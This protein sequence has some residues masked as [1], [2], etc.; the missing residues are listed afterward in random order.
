MPAGPWTDIRCNWITGLLE[1][2][3]VDSILAVIDHLTKMAHFIPCREKMTAKQLA[4]L[5]LRHVQ[6]LH[7]TPETMVPDW[8][9]I[10]ISQITKELGKHLGI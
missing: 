3:G 4:D 9:S 8:A 1:S 7:R 2:N 5:M 6:E 10:F